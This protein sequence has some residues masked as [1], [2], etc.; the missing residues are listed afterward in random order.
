M[1]QD[2]TN[3][4]QEVDVYSLQKFGEFKMLH[5]ERY[6]YYKKTLVK[7]MN[8]HVK[9]VISKNFLFSVLREFQGI[10]VTSP[11]TIN[12]VEYENIHILNFIEN[13]RVI[14]NI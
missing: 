10:T 1:Q 8:G 13:L 6:P 11:R 2:S 3:K 14:E 4:L 7:L 12:S 5:S 9:V